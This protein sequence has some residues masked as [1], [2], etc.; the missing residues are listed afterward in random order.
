MLNNFI[1]SIFGL[2]RIFFFFAVEMK[3]IDELILLLF[4][5]AVH[6]HGRNGAFAEAESHRRVISR[7][8]HHRV[9]VKGLVD[10][11]HQQLALDQHFV[12]TGLLRQRFLYQKSNIQRQNQ[13][14]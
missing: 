1:Q 9:T 4:G 10:L 7:F 14:K 2:L 12:E 5:V 13:V 11:V 6:Q 8:A 3:E